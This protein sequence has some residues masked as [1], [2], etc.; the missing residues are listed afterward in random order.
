MKTL[1][2]KTDVENIWITDD[3]N[4]FKNRVKR[5]FSGEDDDAMNL[6]HYYKVDFASM[7][8]SEKKYRIKYLW[9]KVKTVYN[10]VRFLLYITKVKDAAIQ[11]E[12]EEELNDKAVMLE[13]TKDEGKADHLCCGMSLNDF[14]LLWMCFMSL[15]HW[16]NML[17]TPI[18]MLWP[19]TF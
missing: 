10:T 9:Y 3:P 14:V 17:S 2:V 13:D 18:A 12:E 15:I 4:S 1:R 8:P 5:Y 7:T 6:I 16:M 19:D 11:E